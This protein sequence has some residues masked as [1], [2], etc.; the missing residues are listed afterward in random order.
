MCQPQI[1]DESNFL[2]GLHRMSR[3]HKIIYVESQNPYM[4]SIVWFV[5]R[6]I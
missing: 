5:V 2:K 6:I 4:L 1:V 3:T